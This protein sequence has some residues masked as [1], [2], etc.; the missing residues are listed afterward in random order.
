MR[1]SISLDIETFPGAIMKAS[2]L[3]VKITSLYPATQYPATQYPATQ[4]PATQH[5]AKEMGHV[6]PV[7]VPAVR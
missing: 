4:Y 5:P 3:D 7:A 6:G 2:Y 1:A